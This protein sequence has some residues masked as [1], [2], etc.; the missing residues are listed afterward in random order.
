[1][2]YIM[3]HLYPWLLADLGG[4]N[5]RFCLLQ[6]DGTCNHELILSCADYPHVNDAIKDYLA[7]IKPK[8]PPVAGAFCVAAPPDPVYIKFVNQPWAFYIRDVIEANGFKDLRIINDFTAIAL[9]VPELKPEHKQQ[10]G[11]G[12]PQVGKPIAILG[13]GTGLGVSTLVP[14]KDPD[15]VILTNNEGGHFTIPPMTDRESAVLGVLRQEFNHVSAERVLSGQGIVNI[16]NALCSIDMEPV[17]FSSPAEIT[18]PGLNH[19]DRLATETLDLFCAFLGTAASNLC[20]TVAGYGGV[21]LA[22]GI[23]PRLGDFFIHSRFRKRFETKGR[24]S[25]YL[26]AAPTYLMTHPLPAMLGLKAMVER[27][28][29]IP[30]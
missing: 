10:I 22:G 20:I 12:A 15:F 16:Y 24:F 26:E 21:Y 1:M 17:K 3:Q 4:T 30:A 13:P 2:V 27:D 23:L 29:V 28:M 9:A 8:Q 14:A 19:T 6:A 18:A 11:G 7:K 25:H 5:A